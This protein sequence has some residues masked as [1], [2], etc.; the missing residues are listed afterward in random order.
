MS[1]QPPRQHNHPFINRTRRHSSFFSK[2]VFALSRAADVPLQHQILAHGLGVSLISALGSNTILPYPS[3]ATHHGLLTS[4]LG[5]SPYRTVLLS[6]S[7]GA[8]LKQVVW[9]T[10][11]QQENM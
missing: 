5:L 2:L 11:I 4:F 6:M 8:I 3:A 9:H 7:A 1:P 10:R